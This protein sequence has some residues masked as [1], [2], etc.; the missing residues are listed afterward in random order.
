MWKNKNLIKNSR[1]KLWGAFN[2]KSALN[3]PLENCSGMKEL[4]ADLLSYCHEECQWC[5]KNAF[6]VRVFVDIH[7]GLVWHL[8][9]RSTGG[10]LL[11]MDPENTL[12]I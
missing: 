10:Y 11:I 2:L 8:L 6:F 4:F 3:S 9:F 12:Y 7:P 1:H 5:K